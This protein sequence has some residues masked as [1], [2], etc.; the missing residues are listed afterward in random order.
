MF[1]ESVRTCQAYILGEPILAR[2]I[3]GK[4]KDINPKSIVEKLEDNKELFV[5][6][7]VR[8]LEYSKLYTVLISMMEVDDRIPE[9]EKAE[10]IEKAVKK[11]AK[12]TIT[13]Q[14]L[15]KATCIIENQY[16]TRPQHDYI[17]VT[18]ISNFADN[19]V[20]R[21]IFTFMLC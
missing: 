8:N 1:L 10:I 11:A 20:A 9:F 16:L 6:G 19:F 14:S 17:L 5:D 18:H 13:E 3:K 21:G 12:G 2:W 15:L 4:G 7:S